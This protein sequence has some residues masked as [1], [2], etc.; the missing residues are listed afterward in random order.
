MLA[1][2]TLNLAVLESVMFLVIT[3]SAAAIILLSDARATARFRLHLPLS[4][5]HC[6]DSHFIL[7]YGLCYG[8]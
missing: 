3:T 5:R 6:L 1:V 8:H 7:W 2:E 4:I